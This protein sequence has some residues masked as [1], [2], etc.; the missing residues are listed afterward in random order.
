MGKIIY[1]KLVRDKIPEIILADNQTPITYTLDDIQYRAALLNKLIEEATELRDSD[2][3][4]QERAD[5]AE[6]LLALDDLLGFDDQS[7]EAARRTKE[8]K[9]GG[10]KNRIFLTEALTHE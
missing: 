4:L 8:V 7:T 9:R 5:I 6:V 10:F 1:N 3:S 2:G